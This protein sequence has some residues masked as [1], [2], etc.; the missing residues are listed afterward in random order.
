MRPANN[1]LRNASMRFECGE[2]ESKGNHTLGVL[3]APLL[4]PLDA[5]N[6]RQGGSL[7]RGNHAPTLPL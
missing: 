4:T 7:Q 1:T 5:H 3:L 6:E 2:G